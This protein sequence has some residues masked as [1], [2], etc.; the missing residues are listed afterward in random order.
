MYRAFISCEAVSAAEE[1][2]RMSLVPGLGLLWALT[3]V[4]SSF[5]CEGWFCELEFLG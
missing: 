1:T 3:W 2:G 5:I 4:L